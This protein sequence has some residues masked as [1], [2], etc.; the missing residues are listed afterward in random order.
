MG[1]I[2]NLNLTPGVALAVGCAAGLLSTFGFCKMQYFLCDQCGLHDT[3]GIHNL[4]GMP[5]IL[6]GILSVVLP[7]FVQF[8]P[9][10][11]EFGRPTHQLLGIVVTLMFSIAEDYVTGSVMKLLGGD[12]KVFDDRM[13]WDVAEEEKI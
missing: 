13:F 9:G 2:A 11:G 8:K 6:G 1:A 5:S 4:H 7:H 12:G 10:T 3:C